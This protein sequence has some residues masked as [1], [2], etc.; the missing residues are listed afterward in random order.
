MFHRKAAKSFI[1]KK[2]LPGKKNSFL[3]IMDIG[4]CLIVYI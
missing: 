4:E 2:R 1:I 3:D